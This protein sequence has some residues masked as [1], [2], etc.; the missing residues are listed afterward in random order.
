M[1]HARSSGYTAV[2]VLLS[3]TVLAIGAAGVMSMQKAAIQG[4]NDAR[5]LDTANA[6][7]HT[8]MDRLRTDATTWTL[9]STVIAN[10]ATSN[11][12]TTQWLGNTLSAFFL[13]TAPAAYPAEGKSSA[14]DVFGRDLIATD[15]AKAVFCTHIKLEALNYDKNNNPVILGATVLVFWPSPTSQRR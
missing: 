6:I 10:S 7:A 8:W 12:G 11:L 9:P 14:F 15:A 13:P 5:Q 2:E 4:N 1:S 3:M